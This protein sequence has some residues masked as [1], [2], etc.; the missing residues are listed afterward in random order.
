[1]DY[2]AR[3]NPVSEWGDHATLAKR[4]HVCKSL[5]SYSQDMDAFIAILRVRREHV[6]ANFH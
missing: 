6:H 5:V 4:M 3:V 1:M 2:K